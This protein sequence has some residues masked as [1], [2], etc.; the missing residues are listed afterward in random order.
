M[1]SASPV[2][3]HHLLT[4][5]IFSSDSQ[6]SHGTVM[7]TKATN[8]GSWEESKVVDDAHIEEK[9]SREFDAVA[10]YESNAGRLVVDPGYYLVFYLSMR[11]L[12]DD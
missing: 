2:L 9:R 1:G 5:R 3:F 8:D 4:T 11:R 7:S 6:W 10:Y 12:V